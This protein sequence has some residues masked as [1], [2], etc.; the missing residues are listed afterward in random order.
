MNTMMTLFNGKTFILVLWL[1]LIKP[2]TYGQYFNLNEHGR[3]SKIEDIIPL[4]I[5]RGLYNNV[6]TVFKFGRSAF[7]NS[8]SSEQNE[9]VILDGT[10]DVTTTKKYLRLFRMMVINSGTNSSVT[11][12]NKGNISARTQDGD[13]II[14]QIQATNGQTLM[15]VYTVPSGK[16][17]YITGVGASVGQGKQVYLKFKARNYNTNRGA[18]STKYTL[19]FY[20]QS[21][22][23]SLYTPLMIPEK[24]DIS[25]TAST[26]SGTIDVSASFGMILIDN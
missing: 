26:T 21:I 23:Q 12:A 9:V 16:T 1:L 24:T 6:S 2:C 8:A 13:T 4:S 18:F 17:A 3:T 10:T 19:D 25:V 20:Q 22:N 11:D 14:A 7:V 5:S 15:A